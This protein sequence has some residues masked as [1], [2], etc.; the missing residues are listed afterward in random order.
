MIWQSFKTAHKNIWHKRGLIGVLYLTNLLVAMALSLPVYGRM[1]EISRSHLASELV[2]G[3]Y[4]DHFIEFWR[5]H[6]ESFQTLFLAALG[7]GVLYLILNT[8][9]AGGVLSIL[10]RE[11]QFR[12]RNFLHASADYF[13]RYF[14]LFLLSLPM[15][16][17]LAAVFSLFIVQPL[18]GYAQN[19]N[20]AQSFRIYLLISVLGLLTLGFWNM[21]FDYAKIIINGRE[22]R[23]AAIG[24]FK[25]SGFAL[26]HVLQTT[27]LYNLNYFLLLGLFLAYLII[28]SFFRNATAAQTFAL[29]AFQ[30]LFIVSRLWLKLSFFASQQDFYQSQI[31]RSRE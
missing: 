27:G 26:R 25:G 9:F 13:G 23:S 11:E 1:H 29:L 30:Q 2:E 14:R 15:L 20:A 10:G 5:E 6:G 12:L 22:L 8:F 3:F 24:F 28:E 31:A 17:L 4:V 7:I 18:G 21:L 16:V 19:L